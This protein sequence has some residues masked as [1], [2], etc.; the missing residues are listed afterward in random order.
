MYVVVEAVAEGGEAAE[1]G[2]D[3]HCGRLHRERAR[4]GVP[5]HPLSRGPV[6]SEG[7]R[8]CSLSRWRRSRRRDEHRTRHRESDDTDGGNSPGTPDRDPA[9]RSTHGCHSPIGSADRESLG[10]SLLAHAGSMGRGRTDATTR[11]RVGH[12][13]GAGQSVVATQSGLNAPR[14]QLMVAVGMSGPAF[15]QSG[16]TAAG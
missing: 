6:S 14:P 12:H 15:P 4:V 16:A 7:A 9:M 10:R 2:A 11:V 8:R 5:V 3:G 1:D 13:W